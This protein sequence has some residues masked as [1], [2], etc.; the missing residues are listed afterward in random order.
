[1]IKPNIQD[2]DRSERK[3]K[4]ERKKEERG[5]KK[6]EV[7]L[8]HHFFGLTEPKISLSQSQKSQKYALVGHV[9]ENNGL[10]EAKCNC[11]RR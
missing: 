8:E 7:V 3:R 11:F 6:K 1:M 2:L 4:K 10:G 5:K 9:S